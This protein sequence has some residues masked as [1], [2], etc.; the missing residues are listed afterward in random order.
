MKRVNVARAL[1]F[2]AHLVVLDQTTSARARLHL[3]DE[4]RIVLDLLASQRRVIVLKGRQVGISTV[5]CLFD[6]LFAIANPGAPIGIVADTEDKAK[7][8][9][10]KIRLW[11]KT[12]GVPL[13]VENEK[14]IELANGAT[15]D[16]LSAVSH[17]A[18]GQSRAGRSRSYVLLHCS[19]L[20]F[21]G[22]DKAT[23][24]ALTS[25]ASPNAKVVIESTA[26]PA[27][28]LFRSIWD[29][30][31]KK[32]EDDVADER[33]E[34]D[35]WFPV[36]LSVEQHVAYRRDESSISDE[37]WESLR[38]EYGFKRRDSAAWWWRKLQEDFAGDVH[39]CLREFPIVA[40]HAF[41]FAE[42]RWIFGFT[43][44]PGVVKDGPWERY[45]HDDE[46][47]ILGVDT[48]HGMGMDSSTIAVLG[49]KSGKLHETLKD[50]TLD[51]VAFVDTLK[52]ACKRLRPIAVV[53]EDNG[54]G[55]AVWLMMR[56]TNWPCVRQHSDNRGAVGTGE[57]DVRMRRLKGAIESGDTPIGP[58]L[59]YEVAHSVKTKP[60]HRDA[61]GLFDG[62]DDLLNAVS[63][64][65][66]WR[67]E[68]MPT[69]PKPVYQDSRQR[70]RPSGHAVTARG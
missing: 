52:A 11:A 63:F 48:G 18:E 43:D 20:A 61:A 5:C 54:V 3:N 38:D 33:D 37:R 51:V 35:G 6:L 7:G 32:P 22:T 53:I 46:H 60:K 16:A 28:N 9:L 62:P 30:A 8:L 58:D 29:R 57:K 21:W 19:E 68:N 59:Q 15:I 4:Q 14:S 49:H 65:L 23:F 41:S 34:V 69:E 55:E 27:E 12:I 64:A 47:V 44:A 1:C 13:N 50:A 25:S 39:A 17:A 56:L 26:S 36:F 66:K 2:A 42:G 40:A 45:A 31:T 70:L 24:G 67:S 10:K